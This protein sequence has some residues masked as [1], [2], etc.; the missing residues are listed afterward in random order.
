MMKREYE[1][2]ELELIK[3]TLADVVL[4]STE[5]GIGE[6]IGGGNDDGGDPFDDF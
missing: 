6:N 3:L 2:P 1:S 4:A 5:S